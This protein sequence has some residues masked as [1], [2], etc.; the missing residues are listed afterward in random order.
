MDDVAGRDLRRD[1]DQHV[2][3]NLPALGVLHVGAV[4]D[5]DVGSL[6]QA[7]AVHQVNRQG[8]VALTLSTADGRLASEEGPSARGGPAVEGGAKHALEDA[9]GAVGELLEPAATPPADDRAIERL[10]NG[11]PCPDEWI[12]DGGHVRRHEITG[13]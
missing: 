6:A 12:E 5:D 4:V 11:E 8:W 13:R 7:L 3:G 10:V 1:L 9:F 2:D